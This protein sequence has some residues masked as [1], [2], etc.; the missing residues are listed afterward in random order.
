MS[1]SALF[2][3]QKSIPLTATQVKALF[4]SPITLITAPGAGKII[5]VNRIV[6]AST[7][8]TAAYTG[9]NNLEFRYTG[10]SGAKVTAD[11]AA[12]TLNFASGVQYST[13]AGVVTELV[14]VV[15]AAVVV[16]VPTANP[17]AGDSPVMLY[18]EYNERT[19]P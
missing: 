9:S 14:P 16:C 3:Y 8:A 18:V 10:A 17:A 15:N 11:I 19:A 6:F 12:A 2:L 13:V 7:F 5:T 1:S 4:S